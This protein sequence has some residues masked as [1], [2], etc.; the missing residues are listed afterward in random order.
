[1]FVNL[2]RK[3]VGQETP[4]Y[5]QL[6]SPCSETLIFLTQSCPFVTF[7]CTDVHIWFTC[8]I[9]LFD[10][11]VLLSLSSLVQQ[12]H[13]YHVNKWPKSNKAFMFYSPGLSHLYLRGVTKCEGRLVSVHSPWDRLMSCP[14]CSNAFA[15]WLLKQA[16]VTLNRINWKHSEWKVKFSHSLLLRFLRS[17][18]SKESFLLVCGKVIRCAPRTQPPA[19]TSAVIFSAPIKAR[20]QHCFS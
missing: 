10:S 3:T 12:N 13:F 15:C 5:P 1:M 18:I 2:T 7:A 8:N 20:P 19:L 11:G 4:T 9:S 16:S 14:R 17:H 6:W